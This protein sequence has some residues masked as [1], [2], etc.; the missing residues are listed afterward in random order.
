MHIDFN[1]NNLTMQSDLG[2]MENWI[3]LHLILLPINY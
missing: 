2:V 3:P 1:K